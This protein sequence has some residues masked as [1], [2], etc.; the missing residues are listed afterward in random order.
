MS[1]EPVEDAPRARVVSLTKYIPYPSIAHAGGRYLLAHASALQEFADVEFLAPD[2][3]VN[4]QALPQTEQRAGLLR[5][6]GAG[7]RGGGKPFW[8]IESALAGSAVPLPWRRLFLS[9]RGPW[10]ALQLAAVVEL[11]W[12]EMIALAP[13]VRRRLPKAVL[14]GVA[15][16][17]ITQRWE[18]AAAASAGSLQAAVWRLA[19]AR[20]RAREA[21]SYAALDL[22]IVFSDKDAELARALCPTVRVEVVHPGLESGDEEAGPFR[23]SKPTVLFTGALARRDNATAIEWFI[24]SVWPEVRASVNTAQLVVAGSNPS[25]RLIDLVRNDRSISV[26]GYVE[27]LSPFYNA[28][29]VFVAPLSTGAGVKFK[30]LEALLHGLPVVAT[31]VG[32]EGVNAPPEFLQVK[33]APPEFA[34]AVVQQLR[35]P[36]SPKSDIRS[37]AQSV[38]GVD[39][40]QSRLRSIFARL[41]QEEFEG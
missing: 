7:G 9:D 5:G 28:A 39:A 34:A 23:S 1:N 29:D 31:P 33:T 24:S 19:A 37:W 4:R 25:P 8:D 15:H 27:S 36:S 35:S 10:D 40:F 16:D 6:L 26:T 30:T 12:S 41:A 2:T 13:L 11:Q 17:V 3:P 22:L 18:R 14:V 21:R 20:S 38:Y 32:A